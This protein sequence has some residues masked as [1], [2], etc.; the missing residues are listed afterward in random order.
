M[1]EPTWNNFS[2]E[3]DRVTAALVEVNQDNHVKVLIENHSNYPV[4]LE[5]GMKLS[6]LEPVKC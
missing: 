3:G 6:F 5:E 1:L 2:D 4:F